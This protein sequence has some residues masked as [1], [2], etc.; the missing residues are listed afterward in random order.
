MIYKSFNGLRISML[1]MGNMRLPTIGPAGFSAPIDH[2]KAQR[3]IDRVYAGGVN[4]FDTAYMYHGGGSEKFLGDALKNF[5]RSSFYLADKM[6]AFPVAGGRTPE[7]IFEEQLSRCKTD[8][9]DF[10]LLHNVTEGIIELFL[11]ERLGIVEYL[12]KQKKAGRIRFFGFS[13]HGRP[14]TMQRL[15]D[16]WDCF[17]FGQIQIN[18]LDWTMLDAKRQYEILT[19]R[20]LPVIAMEPCRGGRLASLTPKADALLKAADPDASVASWAFRYL[21][22]LEN[23]QVV[24]SGMTLMEQ[25]EDNLA[26]FERPN[27]LT[28]EE[29]KTLGRA[30]DLLKEELNVPCTKCN[31]CEG[32]PQGLDIPVLIALY[33]EH[34]IDHSFSVTNALGALPEEKLPDRCRACGQCMEKCPQGI[35]I[36]NVMKE[37][38]G[39]IAGPPRRSPPRVRTIGAGS[40]AN[41]RQE[42]LL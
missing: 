34:C 20:G 23:M 11:D 31:Y 26:T 1:G 19:E 18:Y 24:L 40:K 41:K 9:F 2:A 10:Y 25:A 39:A 3:I 13:N 5:P 32:C 30:V 29:L 38:A 12:L 28:P 6:P 27:P 16:R 7:S 14:E 33:N 8:Y 21:Q 35:D 22:T 36:A 4:Y 42:R 37:F 17:D 15:L